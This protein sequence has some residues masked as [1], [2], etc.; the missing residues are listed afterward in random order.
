[1]RIE[2]AKE[3]KLKARLTGIDYFDFKYN[4]ERDEVTITGFLKDLPPKIVIPDFVSFI[5]VDLF[6]KHMIHSGN[7]KLVLKGNTLIV[8]LD[9]VEIPIGHNVINLKER[10][11]KE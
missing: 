4:E 5:D 7:R 11:K 6:D 10:C 2:K 1:M 9:Y 8:G 3:Y